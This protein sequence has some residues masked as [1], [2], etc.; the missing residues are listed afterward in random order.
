MI[1]S[2]GF[3]A[4]T[5]GSILFA[6]LIPDPTDPLVSKKPQQ[7]DENGESKDDTCLQ[8]LLS[9]QRVAAYGGGEDGG[10]P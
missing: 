3:T 2:V 9:A 6:V 1:R 4:E 10:Q 5:G 8:V 7:A